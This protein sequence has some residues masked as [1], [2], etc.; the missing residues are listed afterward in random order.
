MMAVSNIAYPNCSIRKRKPVV[1]VNNNGVPQGLFPGPVLFSLYKQLVER[2][3]LVT[4]SYL[5][6]ILGR[7][8]AALYQFG[9][10]FL[11]ENQRGMVLFPRLVIS[12]TSMPR[13]P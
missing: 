2:Y 4:S 12:T 1:F 3:F 10:L 5:L 13:E 9:P 7:K 11:V 6:V 8:I